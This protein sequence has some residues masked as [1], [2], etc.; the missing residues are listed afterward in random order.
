MQISNI[1]NLKKISLVAAFAISS[2][3]VFNGCATVMV[4]GA[5]AGAGAYIGSDSRTVDKQIDDQKI[6]KNVLSILRNDATRSD[7]K[8]F[9][10]D[11]VV[12]NGNVLLVG[13]TQ[14]REY[15]SECLE[16][17]K[18]VKNVRRIFN[19]VE[20]IPPVSSGTVASDAYI[21]SKVKSMLLFGSKISSGRFKVYTENSVVY[22]MGYVTRNEAQRA[23]NQARKVDGVKKI[24]PIFDYMD[25]TGTPN[26][27]DG[28]PVVG[29]ESVG[30]SSAASLSS[31][32]EYPQ[33]SSS[34]AAEV[35]G[36]VDNGGA[37]LEEDENL[38]APSAP[39]QGF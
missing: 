9:R 15:L 7:Y 16:K 5:A 21:T 19:C 3:F 2:A 30:T 27:S 12:L 24:H 4:G 33:S 37:V 31:S 18:H 10:V 29:G 32:N 20:N 11:C 14:D 17:I 28:A 13:E 23:I 8:V 39:A 25:E 26:S 36:N 6:S 35:Q 34:M 38:L 1:K 22:M